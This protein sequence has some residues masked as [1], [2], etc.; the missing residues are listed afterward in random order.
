MLRRTPRV[1]W[2]PE[3]KPGR[4]GIMPRPRPGPGLRDE[5]AAWRRDGVD[6]VVSLLEEFEMRELDLADEPS[7][8]R[9]ANI[10]FISYPIQDRGVP[11]S[12]EKTC[13]LVARIAALVNG[14]S[15]VAIHCRAGIGRSSLIAGCV[16]LRLGFGHDEIFPMLSRARGMIVPDTMAQIDWLASFHRDAGD[17]FERFEKEQSR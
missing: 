12:L 7:L 5:I 10:H 4:L 1:H 8:C 13:R 14:G 9:A 17:L 16:L 15:S 3:V 11:A 6:T 2:V